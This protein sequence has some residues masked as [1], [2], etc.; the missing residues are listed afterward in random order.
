[1]HAGPLDVILLAAGRGERMRPLTD[2]TPKPL[3]RA[4]GDS[5]IGHLL[6]ALARAG[7]TSVVVNHAHL[8]DQLVAALG[9]GSAWG[10][11]IRYSDESAGALETGGGIVKALA[12]IGSDPFLVV[13]GDIWTDYP[14][15]R[16][17]HAMAGLSHLVL[18]DNPAH[19]PQGDFVLRQGRVLPREDAAAPVS[20]R[21]NSLP[22][23]AVDLVARQGARRSHS[24]DYGDDEQHRIAGKGAAQQVSDLR[25]RALTLTYS[26][27]GVYRRA[28]FDGRAAGCFPLAPILREAARRGEVSGEHYRG[29]WSDVGAPERL[30]ELDRQLRS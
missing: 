9:D 10:V 2:R 12:Q 4:G 6:R 26:G 5:L 27:I 8:G 28:L 25:D 29:R 24:G 1:M 20:G 22:D 14:F 30:A 23:P 17:P 18:V 11:R 19:H 16:L 21:A 3:L 7:L 15:A 13:N